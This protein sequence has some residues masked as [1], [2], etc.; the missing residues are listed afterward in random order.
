MLAGAL[1][2]CPQIERPREWPR[3]HLLHPRH[4]ETAPHTPEPCLQATLPLE[5]HAVQILQRKL[6]VGA[7]RDAACDTPE[8]PE[9]PP[10]SAHEAEGWGSM[11][12]V[13]QCVVK[14]GTLRVVWYCVQ[15]REKWTP[16]LALAPNNICM[17]TRQFWM[18]Q[19]QTAHCKLRGTTILHLQL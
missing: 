9:A 12:L 7:R 16:A 1:P 4:L 3:D 2:S 10:D 8:P 14:G 5:F 17:M 18:R 11:C 13:K 6:R 19:M 15:K